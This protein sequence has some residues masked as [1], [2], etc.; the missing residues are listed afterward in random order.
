MSSN[1]K[2][3]NFLNALKSLEEAL[4]LPIVTDRDTAGTIQMFEFC[5]ELSWKLLKKKLEDEGSI[6]TTPK[7]VLTK[8]YQMKLIDDEAIW[9]EMIK[10]RNLSVHTYNKL[11]ADELVERVQNKYIN[12]FRKL[13]NIAEE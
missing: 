9:L 4:L 8:S 12:V 2:A 11:L 6:A 3:Q 10:D 5:Y 1:K 7:D 13:K